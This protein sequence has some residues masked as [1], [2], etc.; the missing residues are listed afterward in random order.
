MNRQQILLWWKAALQIA[1]QCRDGQADR[2]LNLN[3]NRIRDSAG[4]MEAQCRQLG[5]AFDRNWQSAE[6]LVV[7]DC[8]RTIRQTIDLLNEAQQTLSRT[9]RQPINDKEI[10]LDLMSLQREFDEIQFDAKAKRLSVVSR[11][12]QLEQLHL[13]RFRIEL[14]LDSLS[15]NKAGYYEVIAMEPNQADAN[16]NIVH[17][18]VDENRLCEGDAKAP[19]RMALTQGR[20]LDFFQ[21]VQQ[22]LSTYNP[23]SAYLTIADWNGVSCNHCGYT[24]DSENSNSCR[25]CETT[26][27]DECV[28]TCSD[29][30][31]LICSN[32]QSTCDDCH[33]TVCD[34]CAASCE[35]CEKQFCNDCMS[36]N[37]RC[38]SCDEKAK[39][40]SDPGTTEVDV[41]ADGVG[42]APVPA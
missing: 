12:I 15:P 42:Q 16:E 21:I 23:S 32:C 33:E 3:T 17:P 39:E 19:I 28:Y 5:L 37:E 4:R 2:D 25:N 7:A 10:F 26:I 27:C 18:H 34:S 13:G 22:V 20:M 31:R 41:H 8:R 40:E 38:E 36:Q 29:C 6:N 11:P 14:H 24:T 35:D 1:V 30:D 9:K